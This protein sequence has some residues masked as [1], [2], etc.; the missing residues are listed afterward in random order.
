MSELEFRCIPNH[1]RRLKEARDSIRLAQED[2]DEYFNSNILPDRKENLREILVRKLADPF[3]ELGYLLGNREGD[4]R[5]ID[6]LEDLLMGFMKYDPSKSRLVTFVER[7]LRNKGIDDH[8]KRTRWQKKT[9][10]GHEEKL[11]EVTHSNT[12]LEFSEN[13]PLVE[14]IEKEIPNLRLQADKVMCRALLDHFKE[15]REIPSN[16]QICKATD[17]KPAHVATRLKIVKRHLKDAVLTK[18]KATEGV[19]IDTL[20]LPA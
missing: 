10:A 16:L 14:T 5:G 20:H 4:D 9:E 15:H 18:S 3:E 8:R 6:L 1:K 7:I 17:Y 19:D 13:F 12:L 11:A 2:V